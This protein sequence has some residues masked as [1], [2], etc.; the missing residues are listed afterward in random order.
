MYDE[1]RQR[2]L[3]E[4]G[5]NQEFSGLVKDESFNLKQEML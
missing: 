3:L 2:V 4:Y 1:L 5:D